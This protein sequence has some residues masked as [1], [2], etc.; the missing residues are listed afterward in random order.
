MASA[1]ENESSLGPTGFRLA[2]TVC[3]PCCLIHQS[4]RPGHTGCCVS[5]KRGRRRKRTDEAMKILNELVELSSAK[6]LD[7]PKARKPRKLRA[8]VPSE[9][10]EEVAVDED[11]GREPPEEAGRESGGF[12][13][14]VGDGKTRAVEAVR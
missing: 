5:V 10:V 7:V 11:G 13:E 1:S 8:W 9:G 12:E 4:A 2:L 3:I 14:G 6:F